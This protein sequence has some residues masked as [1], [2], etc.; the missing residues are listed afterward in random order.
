MPINPLDGPIPGENYTADTKNF[1]W[2][3]PPE[4]T[5]LDKAIE[6]IGK[7]LMSEESSIGLLTMI[8]NGAT[9]VDLSQIFLMSG[10]AAG[11][12][13]LDFAL[14]LAGPTAH[15]MYLM[16]KTD[17]IKCEIGIEKGSR[18]ITKAFFDGAKQTGDAQEIKA[19]HDIK[20]EEVKQTAKG[21]MGAA[22]AQP[23]PEG[24]Y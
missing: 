10:V 22:M 6:M 14:L 15:I 19:G 3:R 12:W 2:H 9:L 20:L 13:T 1:P 8:K 16:A 18:P 24:G 21:I 11:K 5:D 4:F 17:G 7:R 23:A